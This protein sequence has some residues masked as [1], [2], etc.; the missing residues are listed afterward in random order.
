MAFVPVALTKVAKELAKNPKIAKKVIKGIAIG[1]MVIIVL[2]VASVYSVKSLFGDSQSLTTSMNFE[3]TDMYKAVHPVYID[4]LVNIEAKMRDIANSIVEEHTVTDE[5][6]IT[7]CDVNVYV[8]VNQRSFIG[9]MTYI[10][11]TD[12]NVNVAKKYELNEEIITNY[13]DTIMS[14]VV[15]RIG[16]EYYILN[17]YMTYGEIATHYFSLEEQKLYYD[18]LTNFRDI[19]RDYEGDVSMAD[20]GAEIEYLSDITIAGNGMEIPLYIQGQPSPWAKMSYG[21][22][23]IGSSGC[24]P[25]ALAMVISYINE[26]HITPPMIVNY[27]G[28]R[29]YQNG[30]GSTWSIFQAVS[31]QWGLSCKNLGDIK[32]GSVIIAELEAGRPIIASMRSGTF[33]TGGHFIVLRGVTK[34]G[35]IL[36]NDPNDSERKDFINKQF[37]INLIMKESK[38]MWSFYK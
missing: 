35:K 17:K 1:L 28:N 25:T 15:R 10:A 32:V 24:A 19:L 6:G 22:G 26:E 37:D 2:P 16:N 21:D 34:E 9:L 13:Y 11:L 31:S 14:V 8:T 36:V 4:Y 38:N 29:Y 12:K 5:N 3:E 20:V 23:T 33:T 7:S 30:V 18:S 27:V